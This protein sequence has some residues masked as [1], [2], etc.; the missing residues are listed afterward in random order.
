MGISYQ[1]EASTSLDDTATCG[2]SVGSNE[3]QSKVYVLFEKVMHYM[4]AECM[5][6]F[7]VQHQILGKYKNHFSKM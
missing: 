4:F 1:L 3:Y 2:C 7:C 6:E 5:H